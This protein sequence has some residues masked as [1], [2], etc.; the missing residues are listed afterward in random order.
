[1]NQDELFET[2]RALL[3][4]VLKAR[5][6][7]AAYAKLAR[8]HGYADGYMRALLDAG[9]VDRNELL[10]LVGNERRRFVDEVPAY[11]AA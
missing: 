3:R 4:D 9:L 7:G 6:D 11:H 2:L 5:F 1:M 8:A 10:D